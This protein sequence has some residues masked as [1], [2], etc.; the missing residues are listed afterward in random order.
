ML[1]NLNLQ[2]PV[3]YAHISMKLN[4]SFSCLYSV[5]ILYN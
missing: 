2:F 1:I 4:Q 5:C 3:L